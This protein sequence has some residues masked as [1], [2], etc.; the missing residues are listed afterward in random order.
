[1]NRLDG[2]VAV[3]TGAGRGIGRATAARFAREG[4]AVVLAARSLDET[5]AL[6]DELRTVGAAA[7]AVAADVADEAAVTA[8]MERAVS[9]FGRLDVLVTCAASGPASG[10]TTE[11]TLE[12]WQAVLDVDL[13]GTFLT[14]REAG[15]H[16]LAG[17]Y[18]RIVNL[19]S[20]HVVATYPERSAYVAAK[21]G[22]AGL[23][24]ALAVEWGGRGVTVNAI[25]PGPI[26][27]DRTAWFLANDPSAQS[28]MTGRTPT[29]RIAEAEEVAALATHLGSEEAGHL[30]GQTVV[31]D[32][33]WTA[34]AWWG[35]HP[36]QAPLS[37]R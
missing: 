29:G 16:M 3:I 11:L 35:D 13:T 10:P 31:F 17:G 20:F 7:S 12:Q 21:A 1:M 30:T 32:G 4:A 8:L 25:A 2:R 26:R 18:G 5:S 9:E 15:K 27:T 36:W 19:A 34:S 22:V 24:R 33:G 23:T 28:G 37:P 14:C 6:A